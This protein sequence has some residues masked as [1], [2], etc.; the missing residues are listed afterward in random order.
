MMDYTLYPI[1]KRD[2]DWTMYQL[3]GH[4]L[5]LQYHLD[6]LGEEDAENVV[7][8]RAMDNDAQHEER[9]YS[10]RFVYPNEDLSIGYDEAM[11]EQDLVILKCFHPIRHVYPIPIPGIDDEDD[12][13]WFEYPPMEY[14]SLEKQDDNQELRHH[15]TNIESKFPDC[16]YNGDAFLAAIQ[17]LRSFLSWRNL[18]EQPWYTR[19]GTVAEMLQGDANELHVLHNAGLFDLGT[20]WLWLEDYGIKK[21]EY[22]SVKDLYLKQLKCYTMF[23]LNRLDWAN[24]TSV[25]DLKCKQ[26]R[27]ELYSPK[28]ESQIAATIAELERRMK[29]FR[30]QPKASQTESAMP[31]KAILSDSQKLENRKT[32]LVISAF[33]VVVLVVFGLLVGLGNDVVRATTFAIGGIV[34]IVSGRVAAAS[35]GIHYRHPYGFRV[36]LTFVGCLLPFLFGWT[37]NQLMKVLIEDVTP[38]I[39]MIFVFLL[40]SLVIVVS[41]LLRS[42][43]TDERKMR[44]YTVAIVVAVMEILGHFVGG[45]IMYI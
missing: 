25:S 24:G 26:E 33:V 30:N 39:M 12:E 35:R 5:K 36:A 31:K 2:V 29:M 43:Q 18:T 21:A 13:G 22:A 15:K 38:Q 45:F 34:A 11:L 4:F 8:F 17:E 37:G 16:V 27:K 9:R 28:T 7:S 14:F 40:M 23:V 20:L 19:L 10:Y 42:K 6:S 41:A 44:P 3:V 1:D 32:I